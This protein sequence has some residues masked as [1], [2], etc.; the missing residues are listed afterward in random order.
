MPGLQI[1]VVRL[2]REILKAKELPTPVWLIR[3]GKRECGRR[4]P[5]IQ[6]MYS[7][8]EPA[9]ELPEEMR[10][11]ETRTVDAVLEYTKGK[12]RILEVDEKQHFN[13]Y[14]AM[15]LRRY[16]RSLQVAFPVRLWLERCDAKTKLERGGFSAPRPPM[17][18]G[19]EGRH[20]QRAFRD[21]LCDILPPS[22][23]YLPTLRIGDFEVKDWIRSSGARER[24][25]EL[26]EERLGQS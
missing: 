19:E 17:F 4:W 25:K 18:P 12:L 8:L 14:R 15:T 24:M 21:A 26:L 11:I 13:K 5:L 7:D 3:P 16:P 22:H 20:R 1:E 10:P 6:A 9:L 23:G 2:V